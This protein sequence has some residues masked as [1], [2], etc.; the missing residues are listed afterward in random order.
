MMHRHILSVFGQYPALCWSNRFAISLMNAATLKSIA[1]ATGFSVTTVSRALGGFDDVNAETRQLILEEARRQGYHPNLQ[2]RAL[3]ARRSRTIGLIVPVTGPRFP[4]PFFSEFVAGVGA[5]VAESGFDLLLSMHTTLNA[6]IDAYRRVIAGQRVDGLILLRARVDDARI[7]Y[8]SQTRIPFVVFGR[9]TLEQEYVFIDVDGSAGQHALTEHFIA[10]G[11]RRI[12]Y[13][14]P[15]FEM[16]FTVY[17]LSG[18]RQAMQAHSLPVDEALIVE[19]DLT[20]RGGREAANRL[21]DLPDPPTAIMA[22]NDLTA[23]GVMKAVQERGLAVG[24][25]VA[26]G[27]F[28]DIPLAEHVHP[29]LTTIRQPIFQIGQQAA[30]TLLSLIAGKSIADASVLIMPELVVRASSGEPRR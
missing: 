23:F 2:A 21:L 19:S 28:D 10:L 17:R 12:A 18:F 1:K 8:L 11:H 20:E 24:K 3:Q 27:G 16:M 22:G 25:D 6:E 5:V 13:I 9:T 29:G 30:Q 4:D 14:C 7:R 26:V 15:P